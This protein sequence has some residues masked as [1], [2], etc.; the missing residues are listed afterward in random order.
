MFIVC[1]THS[2]MLLYII[3]KRYS[4]PSE[5]QLEVSIGLRFTPENFSAFLQMFVFTFALKEFSVVSS[6]SIYNVHHQRPPESHPITQGCIVLYL[7]C[8]QGKEGTRLSEKG[9][10]IGCGTRGANGWLCHQPYSPPGNE[11]EVI[12][13]LRTLMAA[14]MTWNLLG[15]QSTFYL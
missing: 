4:D 11:A 3:Y 5:L 12:L 9:F 2:K 13:V 8:E 7:L 14:G 15:K 10:S 1:I 6:R